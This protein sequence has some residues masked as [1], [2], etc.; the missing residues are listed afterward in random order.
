[1]ISK[2][3]IQ[4]LSLVYFPF[5]LIAPSLVEALS[6]CF[7]RVILYRPVGSSTMKDLERWVTPRTIK[8]TFLPPTDFRYPY[9]AEE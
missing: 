4:S 6:S 9:M 8:E 2:P 7:G 5:T 1:M 3:K